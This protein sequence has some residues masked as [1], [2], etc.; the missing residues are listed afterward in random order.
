MNKLIK[1]SDLTNCAE[2]ASAV[3]LDIG[4]QQKKAELMKIIPTDLYNDHQKGIIHIHDMEFYDVTYNCIGIKV[5]D[6]AKNAEDLREA[7]DMLFCGIVELTNRQS[8]GIGI[9]SFDDGIAEYV[10]NEDDNT[11]QRE[12]RC[13]IRNLNLT[14]RKG[15]EKA[16]VTLNFGLST[17][18]KG[19]RVALALIAAY[20]SGTYVFPNLVFTLKKGVNSCK[21]DVNYHI[22]EK[23]CETTALCMNPTYLNL[24][25]EFNSDLVPGEF[26]IMG[27]RSRIANNR[28]NR[29]GSLHRGNIAA[30]S[31][32]LVYITLESG[33]SLDEFISLLDSVMYRAKSLLLH[34]FDTLAES[35]GFEHLIKDHIYLDSDSNDIKLVLRNGTLSIGFIGLWESFCI[36]HN[37]SRLCVQGSANKI[38]I[39]EDIPA[40]FKEEG[41]RIV[42]HIRQMT[43]L[44]SNET[45]LNFSLLGSSGEGIS[46]FF[47]AKDKK[48]FPDT[49]I[50][51]LEYY[52][53]SF[54][55]PVYAGISC[56]D[57]IDIE[58]PFHALC[59]GG[60]ISYIELSEA[61][62]G[63]TEAVLDV[64][65][66][67]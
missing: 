5:S 52:T 27:C 22:F 48:N 43:D 1:S 64:V 61:P 65:S 60:H 42:R 12:L 15:C 49:I 21:G 29:S 36:M 3:I 51:D 54:H 66:Y 8:G 11:L 55:V 23:A 2:N 20:S 32:N 25:A 31:I 6:Y 59:N 53:N 4:S 57:K 45:D 16:Y 10:K 24:D 63:N 7:L 13:F 40:K 28:F 34:R 33:N 46:G 38:T 14:V 19:K 58:A 50:K 35:G 17:S 30:V 56:F 26:G 62:L 44:F 41:L 67:A 9:M 37:L 18:E 39:P 47:P